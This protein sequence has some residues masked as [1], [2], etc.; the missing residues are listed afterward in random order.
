VVDDHE[1]LRNKICLLLS[2]EPD[3]DVVGQAAGGIEAIRKAEQ[4]QPHVVL[5]DISIPELNGIMAA[6]L[7]KRAAPGTEILMVTNHSNS[8]MVR[9]AFRA[10]V[11]G[12]LNKTDLGLEL[13]GAVRQVHLK[14]P[15]LS[16]SVEQL[17]LQSRMEDAI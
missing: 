8:F 16:A 9:S 2:G 5:L 14:K 3:L 17:A 10:G 12:Y 13:V 7:I 1:L 4:Y 15:F 11:R 6:P